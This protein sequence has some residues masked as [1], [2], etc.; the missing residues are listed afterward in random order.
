[1]RVHEYKFVEECILEQRL[2]DFLKTSQVKNHFVISHLV[3]HGLCAI[4]GCSVAFPRSVKHAFKVPLCSFTTNFNE[5]NG[6]D[7]NIN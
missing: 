4:C 2:S 3:R 6:S 5:K 7:F 1:M